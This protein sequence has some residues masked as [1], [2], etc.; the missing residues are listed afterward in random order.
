MNYTLDGKARHGDIISFLSTHG[1]RNVALEGEQGFL[2]EEG[3]FVNRWRAH[4]IAFDAG[5]TTRPLSQRS[6][7]FTEDLW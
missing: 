5:Q 1:L 2:T 7:L 6:E 3:D 4:R